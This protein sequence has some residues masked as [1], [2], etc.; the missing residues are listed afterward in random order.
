MR[1]L[2]LFIVFWLIAWLQD[3]CIPP[4]HADFLGHYLQGVFA[5][6]DCRRG[7]SLVVWAIA[8]GRATAAS[9]NKYLSKS[10]VDLQVNSHEG[11]FMDSL[12][13]N[14]APLAQAVQIQGNADYLFIILLELPSAM[15]R[16]ELGNGFP[17]FL[18]FPLCILEHIP[19]QVQ[20]NVACVSVILSLLCVLPSFSILARIFRT[21]M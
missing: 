21:S 9:V 3:E 14:R 6:G 15:L 2:Y 5:A 19:G 1:C 17:S 12:M 16:N 13:S 11:S 7:Q 8:E 10:G 18:L 20:H 4:I